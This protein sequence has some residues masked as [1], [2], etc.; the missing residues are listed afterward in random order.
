[1]TCVRGQSPAACAR[2]HGGQADAAIP[3]QLPRGGPGSPEPSS[4]AHKATGSSLE[5]LKPPLAL[6]NDQRLESSVTIAQDRKVE[7]A[8]VGQNRLARDAI[9]TIGATAASRVALLVAKAFAQLRT[10]DRS[11]SA[12]FSRWK[13]LPRQ[14]D[15]PAARIRPAARPVPQVALSSSL[16]PPLPNVGPARPRL[17]TQDIGHSRHT[18]RHSFVHPPAGGRHRHPHLPGAVLNHGRL[19][20]LTSRT[21]SSFNPK[22]DSA[23]EEQALEHRCPDSRR[24]APDPRSARS[25]AGSGDAASAPPP[26]SAPAAMTPRPRWS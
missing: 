18:L 24:P 23:T 2:W 21:T 1:M 10:K 25:H 13:V 7:L 5:S 22:P 4:R 12:F 15:L 9:A 26:R 17:V 3:V 8:I 19:P 14:A 16:G 11:R 20:S 6:R